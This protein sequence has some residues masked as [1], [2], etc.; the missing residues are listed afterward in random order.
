MDFSMEVADTEQ[1]T[2]FISEN[3]SLTDKQKDELKGKTAFNIQAIKKLDMNS[4]TAKSG[5]VKA[6]DNFGLETMK[7]SASQ[8]TIMQSKIMGVSSLWGESS[9]IVAGLLCLKTQMKN[10]SPDDIDTGGSGLL[11][12]L[13][14]PAKSYFDKYNK[15]EE[16]INEIIQTL[17][18]GKSVLKNDNITLEIEQQSLKKFTLE[19]SKEIEFGTQM[20]TD[21]SDYLNSFD[22]ELSEEKRQFI[23][24]E[25]LYPLKQ[26]LFDLNQLMMVNQQGMVSL[27]ILKKNNRELIRGIDRAQT[28]TLAVL[29]TAIL[30]AGSLYNQKLVL[31]KIKSL[32]NMTDSMMAGTSGLLRQQGTQIGGMAAQS[33]SLSMET[34]KAAFED[35][36]E[37]LDIISGYKDQAVNGMDEAIRKLE[38]LQNQ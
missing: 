7:R 23:S 18:K 27:E 38:S 26:R 15:A 35:T 30:V 28:V 4:L 36:F 20:D 32:G 6:I 19:L 34:L 33:G 1:I 37:T 12:K 25:V 3:V 22:T 14:N 16:S 31:K 17:D 10:L 29:R 2:T 21:L 24:D 5:I 13:F 8:N 11:G 9:S